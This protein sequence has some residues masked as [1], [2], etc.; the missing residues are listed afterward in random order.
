MGVRDGRDDR[1][2]RLGE[3]GERSDLA[4]MLAADLDHERLVLGDEPKER[5]REPPLVVEARRRLE[6]LPARGQHA[7]DQL[8]GR[9]LPVGAGHG[10]HRDGE[11]RAVVRRQGAE[12]LG[13]VF[14]QHQRHVSRHVVVERV[15]HEAGRAAR[16]RVGQERVAV[17][18]V[19]VDR[20]EGLADPQGA[21]VDRD[22]RDRDAEVAGDQ[23]ALGG[24]D[25]VLDRK[26]WH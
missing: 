14:D 11:P 13:G 5:E 15:H 24:A 26:R 18:T 21:G 8:L 9:R 23:G 22:A 3:R 16:G 12:R 1:D 17:E 20:E 10:D 2:G 7:G 6:H 4:G 25:D 19:A